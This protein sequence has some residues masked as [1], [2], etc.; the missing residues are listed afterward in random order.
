MNE[1]IN[2]TE[3]RKNFPFLE[4]GKIYL[5]HAAIG[6]IS[7][8]VADYI[9]EYIAIRHETDINNF[10]GIL[11]DLGEARVRFGRL[12]NVDPH[13][14]AFT[15]NVSNGINILAAGL[16]WKSGDRIILN[17][18]EFP[19]NVYP[20]MNQQKKGVEIDFVK[21][22]DGK[23]SVESIEKAITPKTRLISISHVQFLSGYRA[24]IKQLGEICRQKGIIFVVDTIQSLGAVRIDAR[25]CNIDFIAGGGHKWL[26]GMQGSGYVYVS[27]RLDEMIEQAYVGWTSVKDP[28]NLLDFKLELRDDAGRYE[29]ATFNIFSTCVL[30]KS[31]EFFESIGYENIEKQ[32]ISNTIYFRQKLTDAGFDL[33][34]KEA[35]ENELAGIVSFRIKDETK[36]F[37][38]LVSR[39]IIGS[40]REGLIRF[41]PHF[42]NTQMEIDKVVEVMGEI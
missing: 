4:T 30:N 1:Y 33:Y 27:E 9:K 26:M 12:L 7:K 21:S 11:K 32:I 35:E 36:V 29:N 41:A 5:N 18:L 20:F 17:D 10:P 34:M 31:L 14:I 37:N 40:Q 3:I 13:R 23:I 6:P 38:E 19:S 28:W 25:E 22:V 42:Y 15:E 16:K 24:D 2:Q 39:N 8:P